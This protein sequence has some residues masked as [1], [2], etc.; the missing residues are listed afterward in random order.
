MLIGKKTFP[1]SEIPV[2]AGT[3]HHDAAL[4]ETRRS[5]RLAGA[6]KVSEKQRHNFATRQKPQS[7]LLIEID[8]FMTIG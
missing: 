2:Q 3:L 6:K 7:K 8:I 1:C 5:N 4:Q